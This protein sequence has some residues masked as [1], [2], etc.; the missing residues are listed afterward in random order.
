MRRV[1]VFDP[2]IEV[3]MFLIVSV[4][5]H[6]PQGRVDWEVCLPH[7][8]PTFDLSSLF[9]CQFSFCFM[10]CPAAGSQAFWDHLLVHLWGEWSYLAGTRPVSTAKGL[11]ETP[12]QFCLS[13]FFSLQLCR[14]YQ[15][16][17]VLLTLPLLCSGHLHHPKEC[18]PSPF[19]CDYFLLS[20]FFLIYF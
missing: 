13:L 7:C 19:L 10:S 12:L 17:D 15:G 20:S 18:L 6:P 16:V 2:R 8:S 1:S 4:L 9:L 11:S 14:Y 5:P 3:T